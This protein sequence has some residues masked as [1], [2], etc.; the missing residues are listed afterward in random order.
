MTF[1]SITLPS[2][3]RV[4]RSSL[5]LALLAL[6]SCSALAGL[7]PSYA[8]AAQ[9]PVQKALPKTGGTELCN[10]K[11]PDEKIYGCTIAIQTDQDDKQ[12]AIAY[13]NRGS[14]HA[15]KGNKEQAIADFSKAI[16]I[17]PDYALPWVNRGIV[18][19]EAGRFE[20]AIADF[21]KAA[22]VKPEW[23]EIYYRR[24]LAYRWWA[25]QTKTANTAYVRQAINDLTAFLSSEGDHVEARNTRGYAYAILDD[26][27]NAVQDFDVA[28]RLNPT[29]L[30]ALMGRG[31]SL[32]K[33]GAFDRG[34]ADLKRAL[35]LPPR[36]DIDRQNQATGRRWLAEAEERAQ[37][38]KPQRTP[39]FM[40]NG[41]SFILKD[42][43]RSA[44][45]HRQSE[46][47]QDQE[48]ENDEADEGSEEARY[49][50]GNEILDQIPGNT[51]V[52]SMVKSGAYRE[53]YAPGGQIR[54]RNFTGHWWVEGDRLCVTYP[55]YV[56]SCYRVRMAESGFVW[57]LEGWD[58]GSGRLINANAFGF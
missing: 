21:N 10:S 8:Y 53:Y 58:A 29:H 57:V 12:R 44:Q 30:V 13:N 31:L 6:S 25:V 40:H 52:G 15:D 42:V 56:Q 27:K 47:D 41:R 7:V 54:G 33:L 5:R 32:A 28:L 19:S 4:N 26:H 36:D 23:A 24:G 48:A 39:T 3:C 38:E 11:N 46:Q 45:Q 49:L 17:Y 9:S 50:T 18:H 14:A 22:K 55:G 20:R 1:V 37:R 43:D 16:Q 51:V 35:S 2:P 34:I